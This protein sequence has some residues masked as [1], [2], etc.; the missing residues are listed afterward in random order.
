ML[1]NFTFSDDGQ[2]PVT[3]AHPSREAESYGPRER[4]FAIYKASPGRSLNLTIDR[5]DIE[6]CCDWIEMTWLNPLR[7]PPQ[8]EYRRLVIVREIECQAGPRLNSMQ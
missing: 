4:L 7:N 2:L 8:I 3:F 5:M 1:S 6:S